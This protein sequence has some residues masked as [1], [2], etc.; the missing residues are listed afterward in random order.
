WDRA[1][2]F[3]LAT[4]YELP[5]FKDNRVLGGWQFN[6]ATTIQSGLPFNVTYRDG[7]ADRDTG[8][9]RPDLV[10]DATAG[11]GSRDQWFNTTPIGSSGSAFARPAK[12]TFGN[13][14][15]NALV[16]PGYWRTDA[17]IFK[18]FSF[19]TGQAVFHTANSSRV[20]KAASADVDQSWLLSA[21]TP[22]PQHTS[23]NHMRTN[24][25]HLT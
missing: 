15:R 6:Q 16:G 3:S 22:L 9:N 24:M 19:A 5:I 8:P 4:T 17:S 11:G 14:P 20:R 7:G 18:R 21:A 23:T 25:T 10:G 1:H 13:L 12:G 2:N